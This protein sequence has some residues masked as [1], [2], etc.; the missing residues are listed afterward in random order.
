MVQ[1]GAMSYLVCTCDILHIDVWYKERLGLREKEYDIDVPFVA[2]YSTSQ[3]R[4][5][6]EKL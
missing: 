1:D 3:R 4:G 2:K 5:G 6:T